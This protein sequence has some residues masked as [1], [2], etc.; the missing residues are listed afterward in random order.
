MARRC[1]LLASAATAVTPDELI[2]HAAASVPAALL[3]ATVTGLEAMPR[4]FSGKADRLG[5][6][7]RAAAG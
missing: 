4:T 5:L 1:S 6:A 2:A 7:R 3:P